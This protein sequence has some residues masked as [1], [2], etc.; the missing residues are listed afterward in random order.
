M[1]GTDFPFAVRGSRFA[2]VVMPPLPAI[3][4]GASHC[5]SAQE[6]FATH[7]STTKRGRDVLSV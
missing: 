5:S 1:T 3:G 7:G 6:R 2:V 4:R